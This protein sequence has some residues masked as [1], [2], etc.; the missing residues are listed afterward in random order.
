MALEMDDPS[1]LE[2]RFWLL[3]H[4]E[5]EAFAQGRCYGSLDVGLSPR[6]VRQADEVAGALTVEPFAAI[7][8]SPSRR[9]AEAATKIAA[10]RTCPLEIMDELRELHFGELEGRTY[11]EIAEAYPEIYRQWMERPTGVRFP[12]G[13]RFV[14]MVERV[15]SAETNLR[16]RHAGQSIALVTHAGAIRIILGNALGMD[17]ANIFRI[18]QQ[19][20]AVNLVRY[21]GSNPVVG[22]MNADAGLGWRRDR[23][24]NPG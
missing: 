14:D 19:Y 7:Y 24:S 20:G 5:P 9:C 11:D 16:L 12:G 8:T 3:R 22:L 6:G 18:G 15:M 4:P 23:D 17:L 1:V 21:F 10:G 13:E 2:T